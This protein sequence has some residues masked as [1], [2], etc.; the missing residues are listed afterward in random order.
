MNK[1]YRGRLLSARKMWRDQ[2][3]I[4]GLETAIVLIAFVVVA[5]VF[6]FAVITT[7][8]F[9]SEK[10]AQQASAGVGEA[11]TTMV[12]TGVATV[13]GDGTELRWIS[14]QAKKAAGADAVGLDP[15]KTLITYID[16]NQIVDVEHISS[17][18]TATAAAS[19]QH[20]WKTGSGN[21]LDAGEVVQF[22]YA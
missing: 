11:G 14:F 7:G 4:T 20:V 21:S 16:E 2:R 17:P 10:A 22:R 1:G 6:A 19:W 15:S 18:T 3:G 12:P 9:T 5:A 13:S 8:L